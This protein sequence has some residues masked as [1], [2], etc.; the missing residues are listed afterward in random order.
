MNALDPL[1]RNH[2][3][4]CGNPDAPRTIVFSHGFGTDQSAWSALV[5][6]LGERFR[7]V[8]FDHVG[9]GRSSSEAFAQHRYLNL[10]RYAA[11]LVEIGDRL[12]L[13]G[14]IAVGHSMGAMICLLASLQQPGLFSRLVLLCASPRYC[15]DV[16]YHGGMT[17]EALRQT[18]RAIHENYPD[19]ASGYASKAMNEEHPAHFTKA[20][21]ASLAAIPP[22]N[23]LTIACSVLQ[24]DYRAVLPQV[25]VP[26]LIIQPRVD[27]AVPL[28]V[29][30]YLHSQIPGSRLRVIEAK[31]HL[32]HITT[33]AAVLEAMEDFLL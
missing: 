18:Y 16:G 8:R 32:P 9:Q 20:F 33:P 22:Q 6:A 3:T 13:N 15:D 19:W 29:A 2:V 12:K 21:A 23:A 14:A 1:I 11:D 26:T 5:E 4:V 27:L 31:G 10:D 7:I 28:E 30:E 24:S 25:R 17:E